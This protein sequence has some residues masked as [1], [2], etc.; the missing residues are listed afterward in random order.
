MGPINFQI[1][2][3][4][5]SLK[6][7]NLQ[8]GTFQFAP[9]FTRTIWKEGG[10]GCTR[11][12]TIIKNTEEKPFPIDITVDVTAR[13]NLAEVPEEKVDQ[14]LEINAVQILLPYVRT[15]ITNTTTSALMAPIILPILD[16]QELFKENR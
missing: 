12:V 15:M 11:L 2:T 16:P 13:I 6:N 7:N 14:F 10:F 8:D 3:N 1:M 5:I 4:E 9:T